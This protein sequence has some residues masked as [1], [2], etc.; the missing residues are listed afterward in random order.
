M[1]IFSIF[2]NMKVFCVFSL[3]SPHRGD[4]NE[5]TQYTIFNVGNKIT[6]NYLKS[7]A[8]GFMFQG[9]QERVRNSRGKRAVGVR[10]T[11]VLLYVRT[12]LIIVRLVSKHNKVGKR[13]ETEMIQ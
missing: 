12:S 4:S 2:F 3:E 11:E 5:Y 9:T 13:C 10:A 1:Y 6:L 7:A 8:M